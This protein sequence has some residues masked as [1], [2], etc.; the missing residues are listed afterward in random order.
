MATEAKN[1]W[2]PAGRSGARAFTLTEML[3]AMGIMGIGL[4]MVSA[5]FPAAIKQQ[6]L[7]F[8]DTIGLQICNNG[9]AIAK[10]SP[11]LRYP[12]CDGSHARLLLGEWFKNGAAPNANWDPDQWK[13]HYAY[14]PDA[15]GQPAFAKITGNT[16]NTIT[17]PGSSAAEGHVLGY[18]EAVDNSYNSGGSASFGSIVL[19]RPLCGQPPANVYQFAAISYRKFNPASKV[20]V[21]PV[22][23][24]VVLNDEQ[25]ITVVPTPDGVGLVLGT[26]VIVLNTGDFAY[27]DKIEAVDAAGAGTK[28]RLT[29]PLPAMTL[30][31]VAIVVE[32]YVTYRSPVLSVLISQGATRRITP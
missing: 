5:M 26:P 6:S 10:S 27:V 15:S 4:T 24:T 12:A 18:A 30:K 17:V 25:H 20:I 13:G 22:Q 21:V 11:S 29:Q 19:C 31:W 8:Q 7:T 9:L 14:V 3:I 32:E 23:A 16:K 2:R 28:G 1:K